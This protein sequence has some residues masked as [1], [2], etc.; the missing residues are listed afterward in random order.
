MSV[1]IWRKLLK[2]SAIYG[3]ADFFSKLLSFIFFPL[4]ARYISVTEFGAMELIFTIIGLL[5]VI[6]NV[7]LNNAVQRFYWDKDTP[8]SSRP[9]IVSSALL[10]QVVA[11]LV[12]MLLGAAAVVSYGA[13]VG[14]E[15]Q[16]F[17]GRVLLFALVFMAV[18]Q[19]IQFALDV[20]RLHFRPWRFF[21]LSIL[22]RVC[23]LLLAA[24]L[25][26]QM[27]ARLDGILGA[28]ALVAV[29]VLPLAL[30]LIG[31][32]LVLGVS[33]AW[34]KTL[35]AFGYPF[36]FAAFA[37]WIFGAIDRWM[38]ACMSS[39]E[40][41]GIYS[42]A[43]RFSSVVLFVSMAFGQAWSPVAMKIRT[44]NP[45]GYRRIFATVLLALFMAMALVGGGVALFS[46][47][48]IALLLPEEYQGS[49]AVLI[50]LCLGVVLQT[51]QQVTAVGISIE[52]K[53]HLIAKISWCAVGVNVLLNLWLI[54]LFGALGA[55][56]ATAV[57]Y[58]FMTATYLA[59][60]Q[61]LHPL[62]ISWGR[63]LTAGLAVMGL[64]GVALLARQTELA[65]SVI[66][67]KC[68]ALAVFCGIGAFVLPLKKVL[69]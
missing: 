9:V 52:R 28:Q 48:G 4:M 6:V 46:G 17:D 5:G 37:Y 15:G 64:F 25:V 27:G 26:I 32:D 7:G 61:H 56:W 50:P 59:F 2:D 24:W 8:E 47:E 41:V 21:A 49:A 13:V 62:D 67:L 53:S 43:F 23:G 36:I 65:F 39:V 42:V 31:K 11:G 12:V 68:F 18:S 66:I 3:G 55:A 1:S 40:E 44:E 63:L 60:T 22:S 30:A 20:L 57:T 33:L 14:W 38:L 10:V 69:S 51:T 45:E 19:W 29:L 35:V 34:A 16:S 58:L 54:P